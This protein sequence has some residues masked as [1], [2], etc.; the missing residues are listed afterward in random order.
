MWPVDETGRYSVSPSTM[1]MIMV[2]IRVIYFVLG[3]KRIAK[4]I[5]RNPKNDTIGATV[6]LLKLKISGLNVVSVDE[7]DIRINPNTI[8]TKPMAIKIK[9]IF[10][11]VNFLSSI[12]YFD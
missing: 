4:M 2:C 1:A 12:I 10:P 5:N 7:P 3:L 8:I 6:I 11:R 9:L